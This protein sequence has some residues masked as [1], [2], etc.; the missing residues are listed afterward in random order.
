MIT[1][2]KGE[3]RIEGAVLRVQDANP[4]LECCFASYPLDVPI[5]VIGN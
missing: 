4:T 2:W 5:K 1:I 3:P